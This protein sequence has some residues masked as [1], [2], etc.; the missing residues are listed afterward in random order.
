[1]LF[2]RQFRIIYADNAAIMTYPKAA[3]TILS[4]GIAHLLHDL[5]KRQGKILQKQTVQRQKYQKN[6]IF[7]RKIVVKYGKVC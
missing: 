5:P 7:E 6:C 4:Y 3:Q 1:M 2:M